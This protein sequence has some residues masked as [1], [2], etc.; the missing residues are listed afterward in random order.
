MKMN[1][2]ATI[3]IKNILCRLLIPSN[4]SLVGDMDGDIDDNIPCDVVGNTVGDVDGSIVGGNDIRRPFTKY[5][6]PS[7]HGIK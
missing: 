7:N 1:I 6:L 5:V 2:T 4:K 3:T